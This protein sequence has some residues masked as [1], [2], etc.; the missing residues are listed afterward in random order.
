MKNPKKERRNF[1]KATLAVIAGLA[2][3]RFTGK[4][5]MKTQ[6]TK[7]RMLTP[8]GKLVE[9]DASV[10]S[11]MSRSKSRASNEEVQKWMKTSKTS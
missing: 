9:V 1:L 11:K 8:D 6:N 4:R 3:F 2:F 7:I 10:I 5:F